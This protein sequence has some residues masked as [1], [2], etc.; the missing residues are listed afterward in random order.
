MRFYITYIL[1]FLSLQYTVGQECI[2]VIATTTTGQNE[3]VVDCDF[4]VDGEVCIDLE[5]SYPNVPSTD[6]YDYISIPFNPVI[7]FDQGT[8]LTPNMPLDNG[9]VDDKF[10][11]AIP[12]GFS[13]C[14]Y[15]QNFTEIIIGTNGILTFDLEEAGADAPSGISVSNP[16]PALIDNAIFAVQHDMLFNTSQSSEIYYST[17]DGGDGCRM[18]VVNFY[19]A[20]VYGCP[21]L[22]TIQV[23]LHEFTNEI[24][25]HIL[26]KPQHCDNGRDGNSLLG[27]MN[28]DG[29]L[30]ISPTGRNTGEWSA[31]N[32]SWQ[33]YPTGSNQPNVVWYD[34]MGEIVGNGDQINVCPTRNTTYTAEV[35]YQSCAGNTLFGT[36]DILVNFAAEFP[37]VENDVIFVCDTG[38]NGQELIT[39][40]DHNEYISL[41][42]TFNFTFVYYSSQADAENQV[43]P[44][45]SQT[46]N[47]EQVFYVRI[48][49][50][51]NP[52]CYTITPITFSFSAAEIPNMVIQLCDNNNDGTEANVNLE[53]YIASILSNVDFEGYSVHLNES[54]ATNNNNPIT[55]ANL[56]NSTTLWLNLQVSDDCQ[57]IVGPIRIRFLDA[58]PDRTANTIY[59]EN[60]D[61][62]FNHMEPFDWSIEIPNAINL[63]PGETFTVHTSYSN[64]LNNVR[65][66]TQI[67]D[68]Y[69]S[70]FVRIRNSNGCFTIV[71]V[72][73]EVEFYGVDANPI[74]ENICFDGTQD[75]TVD[76]SQYPEQML[77]DPLEGVNIFLYGTNQDAENHNTENIINPIQTITEDGYHV[78]TTYYVRFQL[79]DDCY[80][81][82]AINIRLV[83]PI[84]MQNPINVCDIFNDNS[85][86]NNLSIYD[87]FI[88]GDQVGNVRYFLSQSDA[89]ANQNNIQTYTFDQ[90]VTLYVRIESYGC[91][92]VYP[93][94][95]QLSSVTPTENLSI[96][97]G[98]VCD[99]NND[100]ITQL[101][102]T[103]FESEIYTGTADVTFNYYLNY[104][105]LTQTPSNPIVDP[106]LHP[107]EG[108][109][110]FYVEVVD[111]LEACKA[112]SRIDVSIDFSEPF[113]ILPAELYICDFQFDLNEEFTLTD[114]LP[115]ITAELEG[116]EPGLYTIN[117]YTSLEDLENGENSVGP[118][119][120]PNSASYPIYVEFFNDITGC[121]AVSILTLYTVGAPKPIAGTIGVCDNNING[122]YDLDLTLL[123]NLV[124]ENNTDG[125]IFTYHLSQNDAEANIN[126]LDDSTI[127]ETAPFPD[128]IWVRVENELIDG[129]YDTNYVN[130]TF[131]PLTLIEEHN[132]YQFSCDIDNDGFSNFDLSFVED[133]YPSSQ[134]TLNYYEN[135]IQV[136]NFESPIANPTNFI[137]TI[138]HDQQI[139]VVVSS[140]NTCP[141]YA[142][143]DL[144]VIPTPR[145]QLE[146][147][148]YCPGFTTDIVPEVLDPNANY[149]YEWVDSSGQIISTDFILT[150]VG[151]EETFTLWVTDVNFPECKTP[152]EVEARPYLDPVIQSVIVEG[153]T[154]TIIATGSF[155]M[156][157]SMDGVNWQ[158]LNFFSNLPIGPHT[159]WVRYITQGCVGDPKRGLV[160]DIPNVITPNGDGYNDYIII[161]D[162]DVFEGEMSH[163]KIYDRYGKMIFQESSNS[164]IKWDGKYLGRV[165]NST[166]Y[167]YVLR[168]PDGREYKGSFTVKNF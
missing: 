103:S 145:V 90:A 4:A 164:S 65:N 128:R 36:D 39:F 30:G 104:N 41:N 79:S 157:Y 100:G 59:Y 127:Y 32:E 165:L 11:D 38:N 132:L 133:Y 109:F 158:A 69:T 148:F 117:Y 120:T 121:S 97:L 81:V 42:N 131:N 58:P 37:M 111:G 35:Q 135:L 102:L 113:E 23:V 101:N 51:I 8:P 161:K 75:I 98:A 66:Q 54:D 147:A 63:N 84:V 106:E 141:V 78:L 40:A 48:S 62:N 83:H 26:S 107:V 1:L 94:D 112:I 57:Q 50:A 143:I 129:C 46:I 138:A 163:L 15:D 73:V 139:I 122:M 149:S 99:T 91:V 92:Q 71:E 162:L 151:E 155:P 17:I 125:F 168:L 82:R 27:I 95:F 53:P 22:S 87:G 110:T 167:W 142:T 7:P 76:L 61:I 14:F 55:E 137:N 80:T 9:I 89:D 160:L 29:T 34:D 31:Q 153:N 116:Y 124:M 118:T 136:N 12:L 140:E 114:A 49:N 24:E 144:D 20:I 44:I 88:L 134:Y 150:D 166:D 5:V 159:F 2:D 72:P 56:T 64:A 85:E 6:T 10:S 33:F 67:S 45:S 28:V 152:F 25:V 108:D 68:N 115:Q 47:N 70:Y 21:G 96:N 19:D 52:N 13:F 126:A 3:A 43:N 130:I 74:T 93:V 156:E 154:I 77:I 119:F 16:D 60:C 18:F 123:A 105:P 86:E 146:T